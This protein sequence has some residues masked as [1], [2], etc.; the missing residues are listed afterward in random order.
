MYRWSEE[1]LASIVGKLNR[2]EI[3]W[4]D[5]VLRYSSDLSIQSE[6][7][8]NSTAMRWFLRVIKRC[9]NDQIG[10]SVAIEIACGHRMSEVTAGLF[11]G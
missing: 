11:A 5:D 6:V 1:Y 8:V 3:D 10:V 9:A 4:I 7:N 2:K